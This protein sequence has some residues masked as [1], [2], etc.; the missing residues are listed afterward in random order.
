MATTELKKV[1]DNLTCP[2]CYGIYK[3]P[4]FLP[5]HHSYC[6]QCLEEMQMESKITCPECRKEATLPLGGVKE[7]A[8]NFFI[9]RL[10]DE[11]ILQC[12][13]DGNTQVT[14]GKCEDDPAIT[15]CP[16]CN[17]FLCNVCNEAH[18]RDK[19]SCWHGVVP[20][21]ELKSVPV[22][23]KPQI[24]MCKQHNNELK[25]YCETCTELICMYCTIKDH[26]EHDHD[27]VKLKV[28]KHISELQKIDAHIEKMIEDLT[29]VHDNI[30]NVRDKV[31]LQW[32]EVHKE[33]DQYYS[34][35]I[36]KL[37]EQ[38]EQTV[39]QLDDIMSQEDK[40]L[41]IRE[42]EIEH[43]KVKALNMKQFIKAVMKSSH[44]ELLSTKSQVTINVKELKE[45]YHK[46]TESP[47]RLSETPTVKFV[48]TE[49]M[50]QLGQIY[51]TP[52]T[53]ATEILDLPKHMKRNQNITITVIT[54][55][56]RNTRYPYG[57]HQLNVMLESITG[58]TTVA[59]V[60]DNNDGSYTVSFMAQQIGL[61]K[62]I[63]SIDG[64]P[65]KRSAHTFR[66]H[67][68]YKAM[69]EPIKIINLDGSIGEPWGIAFSNSNKWAVTDCTKHHVYIFDG[70][71]DQLLTTIGSK[72]TNNGQFKSP[73]GVTF[74]SNN[75]LYVADH[76][77]H[78]VQKF[79]HYGNYLLQFGSKG[80]NN[81]QLNDLKGITTHN[82][83]VYVVEQSNKRISVFTTE[84]QFSHH[85]GK[86]QL[87]DPY[88]IVINMNNELMV[89][90]SGHHCIYT[91]ALDGQYLLKSETQGSSRNR[92]HL[93]YPVGLT[94]DDC[95]YTLLT[96][97]ESHCVLVHDNKGKFVH[98]FGLRGSGSGHLSFP[99][100]ITV[101]SSGNVYVCDRKNGRIQIFSCS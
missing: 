1:I 98:S 88:S 22:Q 2:V 54:K 30:G 75:L 29:N 43:L 82:G 57:G 37:I 69:K 78:R 8:N 14:C 55:Y 81:G 32:E 4:K 41:K 79:D 96:C 25:F 49:S 17:F 33:I 59:K 9:N 91:F 83:K 60:E 74:D 90:D 51:I 77:N 63:I 6:E 66:V 89:A 45:K 46:V 16:E 92:L 36:G 53:D 86:G 13:V 87:N 67:N 73:R 101:S 7:L 68:D 52:N 27:A 24:P 99:R 47:V 62:L 48:P 93:Y 28:N 85:I 95:G 5:C 20:V 61:T 11:L 76:D 31:K 64:Q 3:N 12:K 10:V 40:Q 15:F 58:N 56:G 70:N 42:E 71:Q 80:S 65:M 21:D 94:I 26:A 50:P 72:G 35:I 34:E 84:G 23:L 19:I 38:K 18:K 100:Q 39:K 97:N 44:Q